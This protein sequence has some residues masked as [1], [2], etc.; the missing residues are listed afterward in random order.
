MAPRL[1]SEREQQ[2]LGV[3]GVDLHY[4]NIISMLDKMVTAPHCTALHLS[5]RHCEV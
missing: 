4:A 5:A 2:Q 1:P 3:L